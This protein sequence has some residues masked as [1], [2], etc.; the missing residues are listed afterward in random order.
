MPAS[1]AA[2]AT[3]TPT[4]GKTTY[5]LERTGKKTVRLY[6]PRTHTAPAAMWRARARGIR[7]H[8][9]HVTAA[10]TSIKTATVVA[11]S[12]YSNTLRMIISGANEN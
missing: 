12:A 9:R 2:H 11:R 8:L 7:G 6:A 3:D 1:T 10:I 4:D 5:R